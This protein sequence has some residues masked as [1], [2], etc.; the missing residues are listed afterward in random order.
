MSTYSPLFGTYT[1]RNN[2]S[3]LHRSLFRLARRVPRTRELMDTLIGAAAG[4]T[5]ALTP[6]RVAASRTE[7][8]GKRSIETRTVINRATTAADVTT[9]KGF[10]NTDSRIATP[11]NKAGSWDI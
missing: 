9:L 4:G 7:Q 1:L 8:G 3:G 2:V 11:T 5:A 10:I 6:K